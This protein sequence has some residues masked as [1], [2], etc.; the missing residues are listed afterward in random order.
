MPN[1]EKGYL[2]YLNRFFPMHMLKFLPFSTPGSE[3][4]LQ[5][6]I[7]TIRVIPK[8]ISVLLQYFAT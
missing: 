7:K 5:V 4:D 1:E 2:P 8:N 3:K 6:L